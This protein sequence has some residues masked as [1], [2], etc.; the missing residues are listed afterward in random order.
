MPNLAGYYPL[1]NATG[2][3]YGDLNYD[4]TV[5]AYTRADQTTWKMDQE[6]TSWW[7]ASGSEADD[8]VVVAVGNSGLPL[9]PQTDIECELRV[10]T[11]VILHKSRVVPHEVVDVGR[12]R[13]A[14]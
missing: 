13:R 5:A 6:I 9:V 14:A 3:F 8:E 12:K 11:D 10:D 7:R 1:P 4:A 2:S